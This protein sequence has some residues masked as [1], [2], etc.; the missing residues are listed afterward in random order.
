MVPAFP[1]DSNPL[2]SRVALVTGATSGI[3][4]YTALAL[5]RAGA[6][7]HITGRDHDRGRQARDLLRRAAGHERVHFV[8]ADASTLAGNRDL[9]EHVRRDSDR[10]DV[11]VN[12]VGGAYNDRWETDDGYEA[13]LATNFVGRVALTKGLLP[14]LCASAPARVVDVTSGAQAAWRGDPFADL[15]CE[16][17]YSGFRAY[18]RAKLLDTLWTLAL[19]RRLQD[20]G[21]VVNAAA[22]GMARTSMTR[23]LR[24]RFLPGAGRLLWPLLRLAHRAAGSPEKAARSPIWAAV[25]DEAEDVI[26]AYIDEK[27][28]SRPPIGAAADLDLQ[29]RAWALGDVLIGEPAREGREG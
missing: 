8:A 25:S 24:P 22:P 19:A 29:D 16:R 10:L 1:P 12:N 20:S 2:R 11:L 14:L 15:E 18:A 6:R 23:A 4:L 9:V 21:V 26:G 17:A 28:R 27:G 13:T 3:G 5:A 7:V